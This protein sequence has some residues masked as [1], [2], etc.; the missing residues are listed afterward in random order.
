MP[1]QLMKKICSR[2]P[3]F[4]DEVKKDDAHLAVLTNGQETGRNR[5]NGLFCFL[6]KTLV[7]GVE[8]MTET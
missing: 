4:H 5:S 3:L 7:Y 1:R 8:E 6:E 2:I